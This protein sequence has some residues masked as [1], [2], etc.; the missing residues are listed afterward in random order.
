MRCNVMM[1]NDLYWDILAS[2]FYRGKKN[3]PSSS[4]RVWSNIKPNICFF[5]LLLFF[6]LRKK[7]KTVKFGMI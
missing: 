7:E 4:C 1:C 3:G 5:L 2:F 6:F